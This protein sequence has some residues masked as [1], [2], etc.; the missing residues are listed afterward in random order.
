MGI[1]LTSRTWTCVKTIKKIRTIRCNKISIVL[2]SIN[3]PGHLKA[4][5]CLTTGFPCNLQPVTN[6][7]QLP[8]QEHRSSLHP[9]N[10]CICFVLAAPC[11]HI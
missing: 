4:P 8:N 9:F 2:I 6:I 10:P 7:R 5:L 11:K 3:D 1:M